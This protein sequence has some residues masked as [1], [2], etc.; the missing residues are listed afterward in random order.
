MR[1]TSES[2]SLE[3]RIVLVFESG[4]HHDDRIFL[5]VDLLILNI[6]KSDFQTKE[7]IP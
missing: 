5:D 4:S 2:G 7:I 3:R 6:K 1:M